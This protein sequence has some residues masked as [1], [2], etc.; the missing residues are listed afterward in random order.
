MKIMVF[1]G[2]PKRDKS[3]TMHI[4]RAFLDGLNE[5]GSNEIHIID[6]IDSHIE[7]C[8]GCLP[9]CTTAE[10]ASTTTICAASSKRYSQATC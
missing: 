6:L 2:S 1:N 5:A 8:T 9:V 3:D 10:A 4:T 7:Y